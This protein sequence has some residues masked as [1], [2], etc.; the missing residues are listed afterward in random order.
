MKAEPPGDRGAGVGAEARI[1]AVDVQGEVDVVWQGLEDRLA[2][3]GEGLAP[4]ASVG[5]VLIA[6]E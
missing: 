1:E 2:L 6:G 3:R 4:K 5:E